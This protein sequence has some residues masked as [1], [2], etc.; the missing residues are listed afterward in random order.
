MQLADPYDVTQ[1]GCDIYD[2]L[3]SSL[4]LLHDAPEKSCKIKRKEYFTL[5]HFSTLANLQM[6]NDE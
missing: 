4:L 5:L 2:V 3:P 1:T 6:K